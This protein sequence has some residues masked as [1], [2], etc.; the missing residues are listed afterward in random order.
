MTEYVQRTVS[1]YN[2]LGK[3]QFGS[4][5]CGAVAPYQSPAPIGLNIVPVF[6]GVSYEVPNYNSLV[7]GSCI[8]HVSINSAYHDKDCVTYVDR[9]CPGP[10]G[11]SVD[12]ANRL[13]YTGAPERYS[14]TRQA[15]RG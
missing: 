6:K 3:Y 15:R 14:P 9:S 11:Y 10:T 5:G 8:N 7:H 13:G 2:T 4:L 12:A 1:N